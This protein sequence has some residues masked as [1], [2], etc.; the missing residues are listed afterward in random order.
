VKHGRAEPALDLL[1]AEAKRDP[2][3]DV[4]WDAVEASLLQRLGEAPR[5]E[6]LRQKSYR[7]PVTLALAAAALL[8]AAAAFFV[9]GPVPHAPSQAIAPALEAENTASAGGGAVD[10]NALAVGAAV[11]ADAASVV[12]E[13]TK[14][15]TWKL[16]P[17]SLAHVEQLGS[18]VR[19]ALD[20]GS[21]SARVVK[22]PQPESF[23]VRV[24]GTRVAVHGTAFRV[25]RLGNA[26]R[27]EVTEGVVGVGPVGGPSFDVAA[28]STATTTLGGVRLDSRHAGRDTG[29]KSAE[30]PHPSAV[31]AAE[32]APEESASAEPVEPSGEAPQVSARAPRASSSTPNTDGI[33]EAVR[34]CF[35]EHTVASGGVEISV[36]TQMSLRIEASGRIGEAVFTPPL[37]P[38]VRRCVDD[39]VGAM[40][41]DSSPDGFAVVRVLELER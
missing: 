36:S 6:Q 33:V 9:G 25:V 22:S 24:E 32:P 37:A 13:H 40:T 21:V 1:V 15:A 30:R 23:V 3:P 10:G 19:I 8:G 14:H 41:F 38:G 7:T 20:R 4:D 12:V 2:L 35:R 17:G 27:V 39:T 26:V 11:H 16:E 34:R 5:Y 28:P 29:P 18:V 31:A